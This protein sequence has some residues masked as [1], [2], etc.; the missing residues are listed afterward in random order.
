M[1]STLSRDCREWP[2][3][4]TNA[5]GRKVKSGRAYSARIDGVVVAEDNN[6]CMKVR[7]ITGAL[8]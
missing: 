2:V 4:A 1:V 5:E 6:M 3:G 7:A 8:Q